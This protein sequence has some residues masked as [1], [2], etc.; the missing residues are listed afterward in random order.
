[1]RL[2]ENFTVDPHVEEQYL[3]GLSYIFLK[4]LTMRGSPSQC[5]KA[6]ALE[7]SGT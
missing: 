6:L 4:D 2:L 1:M 7:C 3:R 5:C